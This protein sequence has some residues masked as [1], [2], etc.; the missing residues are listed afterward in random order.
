MILIYGAVL[1]LLAILL[2][3]LILLAFILQPKFRAGFWQKIG[4]YSANKSGKKTFLVHAVSVG[5]VNAVEGLVKRMRSEFP[6]DYIILS[7]VTKTGQEVAANKL[8]SFTDEI[9]YFPYDFFFSVWACLAAKMPDKILIAETEIWPMFSF[10]AHLKK[11]PLILVNGRISPSSYNGYKH[12]SFFFTKVLSWFNA[13]YMQ[14]EDDKKRIAAIGAPIE[15]TEVMGNLKFDINQNLSDDERIKLKENIK[16]NNSRLFVAAST[17]KGEDELV[18]KVFNAIKSQNPD[19]KLLLAPRH[20]QRY[21]QVEDLLKKEPYKYSKRS[22]DGNFEDNDIIMLDTMGE[23]SKFF[24]LGYLAFIGGSFSNTGGHN[25]LEA[26]IWDVPVISGP[27]VFNFK[28][29]YKLLTKEGVARIVKDEKEF[30]DL[31]LKFYS[32]LDFHN[33]IAQDCK[34]IFDNSRGALDFVID[35]LKTF[36]KFD[37]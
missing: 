15:K 9:I 20:P 3:P 21:E 19:A 11:I 18:L 8:A 22:V 10:I 34:T 14:T 5:E 7:T 28:D 1:P 29:I 32:D 4:F 33:K 36:Q 23:L 16:L 6:D 31:A 35:K 26:N 25:P 2:L 27:T 37:N 13:I 17:H 12:L 30:A 24:S